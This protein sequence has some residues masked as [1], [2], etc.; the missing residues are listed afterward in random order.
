MAN[1][2]PG[3]KVLLDSVDFIAKP[4]VGTFLDQMLAPDGK[5]Y[6]V[7]LNYIQDMPVI[8]FPERQGHTCKLEQHGFKLPAL[9]GS[10]FIFNFPHYRVGPVDGSSCDTLGIDNIPL[11]EF[12]WDFEDTLSPLQ[13]T[14]T[15][16]CSYEPAAWH[17]DFG[18]GTSSEERYPLHTYETSGIYE[19]CLRVSNASGAD[20][21]CKTLYLGVSALQNPLVQTAISV[22]PNPFEEVLAVSVGV[23]IKPL[24]FLLYDQYGRLL[25]QSEV[26]I[27]INEVQVGKCPPGLYFWE[28]RSGALRIRSGKL[29]K[30]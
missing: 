6:M 4:A 15:E 7:S 14:F 12:R 18:D 29:V 8:Q 2:I 23:D 25:R 26:G 24:Q 16:A 13:V 20:T 3:S 17:W 27:G 5:I 22:F 28:L 21:L 19:V 10:D 11:A 1:D 30:E 9:Y